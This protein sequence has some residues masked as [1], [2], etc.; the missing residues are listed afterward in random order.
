MTRGTLVSN[1]VGGKARIKPVAPK[2][3]ATR[4]AHFHV[5]ADSHGSRSRHEGRRYISAGQL[6]MMA[7]VGIVTLARITCAPTDNEYSDPRYERV[8]A[9][10]IIGF[11]LGEIPS[12]V[13]RSSSSTR[14]SDVSGET[15]RVR[16]PDVGPSTVNA[17]YMCQEARSENFN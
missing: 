2:A 12:C 11:R 3:A 9:R 16:R 8:Q 10:G 17:T 13:P 5:N 1:E 14:R 15:A 4:L 7:F 6:S